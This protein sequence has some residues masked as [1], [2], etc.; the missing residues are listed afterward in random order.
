MKIYKMV[1][2]FF[3]SRVEILVIFFKVPILKKWKI[4]DVTLFFPSISKKIYSVVLHFLSQ[5]VLVLLVL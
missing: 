4:Y 3:L 5:S 1:I 2:I